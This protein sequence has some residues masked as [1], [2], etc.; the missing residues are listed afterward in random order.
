LHPREEGEAELRWLADKQFG[1]VHRRQ[2]RAAGFGRR[3]LR[4]RVKQGLAHLLHSQVVV[5]RKPPWDWETYAFAAVLQL[6]GDAVLAGA[7]AAYVWKICDE[8]PAAVDVLLAERGARD[9]ENVTIHR[10]SGLEKRDVRW[11]NGLPVTSPARTLVDLAASATEAELES[12]LAMARRKGLLRDHELS[13]VIARVP[14][15]KPGLWRLQA[16]RERP[17]ETLAATRSRYERLFRE[18]LKSAN[19]PGP[20]VNHPLQRHECDFVFEAFKLIVE[21]DGWAFHKDRWKQDAAR[22]A[23]LAAGGYTVI[24][25]P[26]TRLDDEPLAVIAELAAALAVRGWAPLAQAA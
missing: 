7:A 16:L 6:K 9:L 18:L 10:V 25:I 11:R 23:R 20:Q 2:L 26:A 1:C 12:A 21:V 22:D 3:W 24:R 5:L 15:K 17:P 14:P 19:L 4:A 13:D 8:P